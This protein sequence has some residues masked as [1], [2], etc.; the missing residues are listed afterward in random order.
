MKRGIRHKLQRVKALVNMRFSDDLNGFIVGAPW[1][2][3][4]MHRMPQKIAETPVFRAFPVA[5]VGS[6]WV[7]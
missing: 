4:G 3:F 7:E 2:R 5:L 6:V 1:H